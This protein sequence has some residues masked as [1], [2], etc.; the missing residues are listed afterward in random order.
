M[1]VTV[2]DIAAP[3]PGKR[4]GTF[5]HGST[6]YSYNPAEV[7]IVEGHTYEIKAKQ[8]PQNPN[9]YFVDEAKPVNGAPPQA[10]MPGLTPVRYAGPTPVQADR[11]WLPFISNTVA[12]AIAAGL[13]KEPYQLKQWAAAAK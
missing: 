8:S 6:F 1:Q 4:N 10:P 2:S 11:F 7:M 9:L 3:K 12:H 13:V 5:K